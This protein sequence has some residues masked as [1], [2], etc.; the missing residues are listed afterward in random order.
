MVLLGGVE[1]T[2]DSPP[3]EDGQVVHLITAASFLQDVITDVR[4]GHT[5]E[6]ADAFTIFAKTKAEKWDVGFK[7]NV[8]D[9]KERM[10]TIWDLY[11]ATNNNN[12]Y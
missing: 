6:D 7:L 8:C 9:A 2:F 11:Q 1:T 3:L 5:P 4:V 12:R 10:Q